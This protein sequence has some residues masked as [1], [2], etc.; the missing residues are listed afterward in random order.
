MFPKYWYRYLVSK[1]KY[2]L[3]GCK[4]KGTH[5]SDK[6][7][8]KHDLFSYRFKRFTTETDP[9]RI[10]WLKELCNENGFKIVISSVWKRHFNVDEWNQAFVKL[11]FNPDTVIGITE[12]WKTLR[13][14]EIKDWIEKYGCDNYAIID[15]DSD[16]LPEQMD[17]FFNTDGYCGLTPSILYRIKNHFIK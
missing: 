7:N 4:Y 6:R 2:I 17:H 11:G 13:G 16:M 5:L 15:D 1:S 10:S 8:P 14:E 12:T 3:N 9:V